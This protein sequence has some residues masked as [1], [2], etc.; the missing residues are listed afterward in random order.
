MSRLHLRFK[1]FRPATLAAAEALFNAKPWQMEDLDEKVAT[2]QAFID[3]LAATYHVPTALLGIVRNFRGES[4]SYRPA[5]VSENAL[6][7]MTSLS[8]PRILLDHWTILG[9]FHGTRVH[10]LA[11]GEEAVS[12]MDPQAWACSLFYTVRPEM[13]RARAREGRVLE[14]RAKDT[15][16]SETWNRLVV[17]GVASDETGTLIVDRRDVQRVLNGEVSVGDLLVSTVDDDEEFDADD[18]INGAE[19]FLNGHAND[20]TDDEGQEFTDEDEEDEEVFEPL[21]IPTASETLESM[22]S[23]WDGASLV[24]MRRAG[25]GQSIPGLWSMNATDLRTALIQRGIRR[26]QQ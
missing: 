24:E 16:S 1:N 14:V 3:A 5:L 23:E 4:V 11:N 6:G 2:G 25:T 10:L 9:L 17:A 8:P 22:P 7:E 15:Y 21:A 26:N 18:L 13:F 19:E 20:D 12:E